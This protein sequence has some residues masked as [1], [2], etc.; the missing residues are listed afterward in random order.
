[1]GIALLGPLLPCKVV[2]DVLNRSIEHPGDVVKVVGDGELPDDLLVL[3]SLG[4]PVLEAQ[5]LPDIHGGYRVH[6]Q[7]QAIVLDGLKDDIILV[8]L[9]E[10]VPVIHDDGV[11]QVA[12]IIE[13]LPR[14]GRRI[15][16]IIGEAPHV[17]HPSGD[18]VEVPGLL[19]VPVL[20]GTGTGLG[21][22]KD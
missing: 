5:G 1:M 9:L 13:G 11:P 7:P 12:P 10:A 18:V 19:R 6:Y 2:G 3:P 15:D 4:G 17:H 22:L 14:Q 21:D 20:L 16:L 8:K